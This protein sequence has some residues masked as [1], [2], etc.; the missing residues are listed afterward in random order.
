MIG[1]LYSRLTITTN[2]FLN[3]A[4]LGDLNVIKKYTAANRNTEFAITR[5]HL[6][7]K[8]LTIAVLSENVTI[9]NFLITEGISDAIG[10]G[11]SLLMSAAQRGNNE[12][13]E[14]LVANGENVNAVYG[15]HTALTYAI[16]H[17]HSQN[18]LD[19]IKTL[20]K[21][22]ADVNAEH[23]GQTPLF[24]AAQYGRDEIAKILIDAGSEVPRNVCS[25]KIR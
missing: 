15:H 4:Y 6:G 22:G 3:A 8:A 20:I 24:I 11:L 18:H 16:V 19:T 23:S 9:V 17:G 7:R 25:L 10:P 1:R 12:I 13:V 5:N 2:D 14:A 21:A